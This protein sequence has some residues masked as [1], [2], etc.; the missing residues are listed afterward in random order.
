[1]S[2]IINIEVKNEPQVFSY[3]QSAN[4]L[5]NFMEQLDYLS[6][7]LSRKALV[8]RYYVENVK[9]LDLIIG[10][11]DF[12]E[13]EI[14][15]TCFCDIPLSSLFKQGDIHCFGEE[16]DRLSN[17]DKDKA[18]SKT[19]HPDFYGRFAISF[20]KNWGLKKSLQPIHYLNKK[21]Q[22]TKSYGRTLSQLYELEDLPIDVVTDYLNRLAYIKPV[23][24]IM[25]KTF[26]D[27]NNKKVTLFYEKVFHDEKE[28]RYVP[29]S[30][31]MEKYNL[32]NI[33][34]NPQAINERES[35]NTRFREDVYKELWL[36][37]EYSDIKYL[38]VPD[39]GSRNDLIN[40]ISSL[41]KELFGE[42]EDMEK[43]VLISKIL[44]LDNIKEDM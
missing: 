35:W 38:I 1:M 29:D 30:S 2:N 6:Q 17:S 41:P 34:A 12:D 10:G 20:G 4:A 13:V 15:Q 39:N 32:E 43:K 28:W 37:F 27:E 44:V 36:N 24:G 33:H 19:T 9:Y 26:T 16:F 31:L 7:A 21:G 8:P 22:V 3:A 23:D 42:D 11:E 25:E 18:S 5:F 40:I 14:L